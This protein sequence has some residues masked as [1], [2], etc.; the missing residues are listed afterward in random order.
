MRPAIIALLCLLAFPLLAARPAAA[1]A[2]ESDG[3]DAGKMPQ[4]PKIRPPQPLP[5]AICDTGR[6]SGGEWLLGRWVG[7]QT[8]LAFARG[9]DVQGGGSIT[10]VLDRKS[11]AGEFGWAPGATI[12]GKVAAVSPCTVRLVAGPD[13]A[14]VLD[15]VLTDEGRLYGTAVNKDGANVRFVLRRER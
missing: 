8:A 14:F 12:D 13:D 2:A 9:S 7:P 1:A 3:G 10:W 4:F 5:E 11:A 6:A 15:G